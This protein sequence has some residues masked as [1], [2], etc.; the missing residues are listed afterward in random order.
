VADLAA[1][2]AARTGPSRDPVAGLI[3]HRVA[4]DAC[5]IVGGVL[6][7]FR[8]AEMDRP[9][10]KLCL[11]G[12]FRVGKTRLVRRLTGSVA[13]APEA[14][15]H[16]HVWRCP[17][18]PAQ[19]FALFDVAGSTALDSIGQSFLSGAEGFALV[20]DA[21]DRASVETALQLYRT[22][23]DL[24][25]PRPAVLMLNKAERGAA[26]VDLPTEPPV[27]QVS[28]HT[29]DGVLAAFSAL[30]EAVLARPIEPDA[31]APS[32]RAVGAP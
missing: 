27:F 10:R 15:V 14:G 7:P 18:A 32:L 25:G 9:L 17:S 24:I 12:D 30:A 4:L 6:A 29:G 3:R 5:G 1:L 8:G 28:A 11:L 20:A 21:G 13:P 19:P 26:V 2:S 23:Q 31:Q 16:L 22:A